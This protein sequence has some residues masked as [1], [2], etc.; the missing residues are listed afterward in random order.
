MQ[1]YLLK[2][3]KNSIKVIMTL[4]SLFEYHQ[5]NQEN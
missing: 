4:F 5:A 1:S 2:D 3:K